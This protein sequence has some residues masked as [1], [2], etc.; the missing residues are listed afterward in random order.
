MLAYFWRLFGYTTDKTEEKIEEKIKEKPIEKEADVITDPKSDWN[1]LTNDKQ[2]EKTEDNEFSI[3]PSNTQEIPVPLV[4]EQLNNNSVD[5]SVN[6]VIP[7]IY[8][9]GK[10][11]D[12][13]ER[14]SRILNID[15]LVSAEIVSKPEKKEEKKDRKYWNKYKL[16]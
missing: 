4:V 9:A 10:K 6:K 1:V 7:E 16:A 3:L 14:L 2:S 11:I 13:L 15:K 5:N 8:K 12:K